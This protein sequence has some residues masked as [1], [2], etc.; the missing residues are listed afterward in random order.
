MT[1]SVRRTARHVGLTLRLKLCGRGLRAEA[2]A[3]CRLRWS[4]DALE[5]RR[6][7]ARDQQCGRHAARPTSEVTS[8]LGRRASAGPCQLLRGVRRSVSHSVLCRIEITNFSGAE[9]G[10]SQR[11]VLPVLCREEWQTIPPNL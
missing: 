9:L 2:D 4:R 3:A 10:C 7:A 1:R 6:E 8:R 5:A 11:F